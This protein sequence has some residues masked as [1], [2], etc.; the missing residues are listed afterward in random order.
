[1]SKPEA[2]FEC[3]EISCRSNHEQQCHAAHYSLCPKYH[4]LISPESRDR[5]CLRSLNLMKCLEYSHT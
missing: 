4:I 1:M 2:R 5:G 3:L